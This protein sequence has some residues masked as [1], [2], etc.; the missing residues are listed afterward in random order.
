MS[1]KIAFARQILKRLTTP[2]Q[3]PTIPTSNDHTD[4]TWVNTDLYSGEMCLNTS[5]RELTVRV[6]GVGV[7]TIDYIQKTGSFN[8][9]DGI[10]TKFKVYSQITQTTDATPTVVCAFNFSTYKSV[11]GK[12]K[13]Y[14]YEDGNE[15]RAFY[16][17]GIVN[18]DI[19]GDV[20]IE[21][22][23]QE[24]E[25]VGGALACTFDASS[26]ILGVEV[27]G[28]AATN[29]NWFVEYDITIFL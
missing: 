12:V 6:S 20:M 8:V 10:A 2:F 25:Q 19:T 13:V 24:L 17:E 9:L 5:S 27:T 16:Q 4:G 7:D 11:V 1:K 22:W 23:G 26:G 29:I 3:Q 28:V 14:G 21:D 15:N 18:Y